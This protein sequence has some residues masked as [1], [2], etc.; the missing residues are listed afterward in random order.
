MD[1][2]QSRGRAILLVEDDQDI[3]EAIQD[4]LTEEGYAVAVADT[5]LS[6]LERLRCG[7]PLPDVILLDLMMPV[8]DGWQFRAEQEQNPIWRAIPVIV[9]SAVGNTH[10]KADSMGAFGCLRKPL[11]VDELLEMLQRVLPGPSQHAG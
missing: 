7:E 2:S 6:A 3:R 10:E 5:G 8:M 9:L 4:V 11:D 1:D